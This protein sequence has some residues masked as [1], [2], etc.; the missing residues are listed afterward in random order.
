MSNDNTSTNPTP[1]DTSSEKEKRTRTSPRI[2]FGAELLEW[3]NA[4]KA[5]GKNPSLDEI[6]TKVQAMMDEGPEKPE[7]AGRHY[8]GVK[9]D[10]SRSH[11]QANSQPT[12]LSYGPDSK[13]GFASVLGPFRTQDGAEWRVS[14][15]EEQTPVIF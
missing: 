10:G 11:F 4:L 7:Y 1:S 12:R 14:H 8:I 5:E 13:H 9:A 2:K 6:S 3:V 15:P